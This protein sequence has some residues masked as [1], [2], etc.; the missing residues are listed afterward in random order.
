MKLT[1]AQINEVKILMR[2]GDSFELALKTVI[3]KPVVTQEEQEFY[4][5]CYCL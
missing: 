4:Y 1:A 3:D 5:N 2:L